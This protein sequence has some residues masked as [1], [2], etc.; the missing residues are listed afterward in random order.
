MTTQSLGLT[1]G[2]LDAPVTLTNSGNVSVFANAAAGNYSHVVGGGAVA[3]NCTTTF[4]TYYPSGCNGFYHSPYWYPYFYPITV[5]SHRPI[6]LT[7][8]E[9]ERLRVAAK[10]DK[11][12]KKTLAKFTDHIEVV[13][14]FE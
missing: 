10:K 11:D 7:M 1:D 9:V 4:S 3:G 5:E 12:L 13:V 6:K 2:W 14:D 8:S